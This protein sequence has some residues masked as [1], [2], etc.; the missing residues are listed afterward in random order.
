VKQHDPTD[1][2]NIVVPSQGISNSIIARYRDKTNRNKVANDTISKIVKF[3]TDS[4]AVT[5]DR[6]FHYKITLDA[7]LNKH[8]RTKSKVFKRVLQARS[9]E[10]IMYSTRN[11][12][13]NNLHCA[14][15]RTRCTVC[16]TIIWKPIHTTHVRSSYST[17]PNLRTSGPTRCVPQCPM[18]NACTS[19]ASFG[20]SDRGAR[21][22]EQQ[23][24]MW[25]STLD[26][27]L[28]PV[29]VWLHDTLSSAYTIERV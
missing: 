17:A 22:Y 25:C 16:T 9:I 21:Q 4:S 24:C 2:I 11:K 28:V 23:L 19:H 14:A 13:C 5:T 1:G 20:V 27:P 29:A 18:L 8:V 10:A 12:R 26:H 3:W 15:C 7:A 6:I